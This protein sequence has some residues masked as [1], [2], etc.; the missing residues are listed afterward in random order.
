M[1]QHRANAS[2]HA[3]GISQAR[4]GRIPG[5]LH[6]SH[7]VYYGIFIAMRFQG[8]ASKSSGASIFE[9]RGQTCN[10]VAEGLGI[11]AESRQ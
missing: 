9:D 11:C 7:K 10:A 5:S 2:N 4:A 1:S 3:I 6:D 8:F